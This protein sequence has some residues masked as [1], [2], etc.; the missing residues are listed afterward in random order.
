MEFHTKELVL[1]SKKVAVKF[2]EFL[3]TSRFC[4]IQIQSG[5]VTVKAHRVVLAAAS[6][7]F[8]ALF[9]TGLKESS[10]ELVDLPSVHPDVLPLVVNY[11]YT[12]RVTIHSST[13]QEL[14]A[15]AHM[16]CLDG[17]VT[18]C[19]R[20]L[21]RQL[22]PSNALS[23]LSFAEIYSCS[24]LI[25]HTLDYIWEHWAIVTR[26][27]DFLDVKLASL[28]RILSSDKFTVESELEVVGALL[29]WLEH[30][31]AART[32]HCA[33]LM[34]LPHLVRLS[35]NTLHDIW[36]NV[37][38]I[39][40]A[41]NLHLIGEKMGLMMEPEGKHRNSIMKQCILAVF[42]LVEIVLR[43][44]LTMNDFQGLMMQLEDTFDHR[45]HSACTYYEY[46]QMLYRRLTCVSF[47]SRIPVLVLDSASRFR[48]CCRFRSRS[49][50][51]N[52][53]DYGPPLIV[54]TASADGDGV[55]QLRRLLR[56]GDH[57]RYL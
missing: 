37:K 41:E 32:P 49:L 51:A 46:P 15:A 5:Q 1:R 14:M 30:D 40:L 43:C 11:I 29:R 34:N 36:R 8:K 33:Q 31:P 38:D 10:E 4:D 35:T 42:G 44:T 23:M 27:E 22:D 19:A 25:E 18:G 6:P 20:F 48:F 39:G 2:E 21:E 13:A 52:P 12:G 26:M 7:Y 45:L 54:A 16:L 55:Q 24:E 47:T 28:I 50:L 53:P 3:R 17:L 57:Q 56:G 9:N